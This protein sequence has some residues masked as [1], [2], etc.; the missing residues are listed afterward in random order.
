[1]ARA[2]LAYWLGKSMYISLTDRA[3]GLALAASRGPS[4]V[5]PAASGFVPLNVTDESE[6]PTAIEIAEAVYVPACLRVCARVWCVCVAL[7]VS[8][9]VSHEPLC[10]GCVC[11]G[12]GMSSADVWLSV[13]ALC[14]PQCTVSASVPVFTQIATRTPCTKLHLL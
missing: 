3:C 7:C 12:G 2:G 1:M 6:E 5:M 14:L 10:A 9:C 4:F 8:G 13:A 11:R